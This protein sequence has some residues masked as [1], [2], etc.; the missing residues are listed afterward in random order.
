MN[1]LFN[2]KALSVTNT[3]SLASV[4][5]EQGAANGFNLEASVVALNLTFVH[6][7]DYH[8][9]KL[10]DGDSIELLTAVVGG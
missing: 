5:A 6:K 3:C 4:I 9:H 7:D 10:K 8:N 1:I 2:G